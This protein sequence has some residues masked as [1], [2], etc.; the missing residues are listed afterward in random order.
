MAQVTFP[1]ILFQM[2]DCVSE[3]DEPRRYRELASPRQ[4][5]SGSEKGQ[6]CSLRE[7]L[8]IY[9][10][11]RRDSPSLAP[12]ES[13]LPVVF[14]SRTTPFVSLPSEKPKSHPVISVRYQL[15]QPDVYALL[16]APALVGAAK[17][18]CALVQDLPVQQ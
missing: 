18:H 12:I 1:T 2:L 14:L 13:L 15:I 3:W 8:P 16:W 10:D 6:S 9:F 7:V 11:C 17:K 5:L 4:S